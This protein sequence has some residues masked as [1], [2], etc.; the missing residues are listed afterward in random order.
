MDGVGDQGA[1]EI[2]SIAPGNTP[3]NTSTQQRV[4]AEQANVEVAPADPHF[5]EILRIADDAII[6][7]NAGQ[8]ITMFNRG[9]ERIFG[10]QAEEM[11][12][13]PLESLLPDRFRHDH[14]AHISDFTAAPDAARVMAK[15]SEIYGRRK[16]GTEFPAEASISKL[17]QETGLVF[18]V[19]LRDISSR[20]AAEVALRKA[21]D[22]M[23]IRVRE[24]TAELSEMNRQLLRQAK[25]LARSNAD[26]EQFAF[27]ASHDL[28]EPLRMIASYTQL[29]GKRY[30]GRIDADADDFMK[31]IVDGAL[32]MQHLIN[33]LLAFSRVGTRGK[34]FEPTDLAAAMQQVFANLKAGI[35]ESGALIHVD[36]LPTVWAD[37]TQMVLLLQ[38]LVSNAIKFRSAAPPAIDISALRGDGEWQIVVADQGIGIEPIYAERIFVIFQRLHT[39]T[40]YP[41]T[42]IGLA[43]CKK[44]VERHGGRI[45]V[46]SEPG[47][48]SSFT[49]TVADREEIEHESATTAG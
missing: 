42:G 46:T 9:A 30:R 41:G 13:R 33:D 4:G 22:E 14:S 23:E 24:R 2:A 19:I 8:F 11:I 40:E 18:T 36:P 49:F 28:Q 26:L 31:Y 25:E 12:G 38:N 34:E 17:L 47:R 10:Y 3:G 39:A 1:V 6:S 48:G 29:L 45:W 15:R 7:V 20:K 5:A 27:V 32:R 35:G 44:I 21:H 37:A 16:D 43:I